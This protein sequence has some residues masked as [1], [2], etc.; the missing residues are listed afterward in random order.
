MPVIRFSCPTCSKVLK[1][2]DHGAGRKIA[3]PGCGQRLLI[4][5]PLRVENKTVLGELMPDSPASSIPS[6]PDPFHPMRFSSVDEPPPVRRAPPIPPAPE[7]PSV[8]Q[9]PPS[10]PF[11][12]NSPSDQ[13]QFD[14]PSRTH[15]EGLGTDRPRPPRGKFLDRQEEVTQSG[16]HQKHSGL[17]I[18][19]FLIA[20]LVVG[21]DILLA[22]VI[23][24]GIAKSGRGGYSPGYRED[25]RTNVMG[26][27]MALLC[28]NCMSVPLCLV[29]VGMAVAGLI[30]HRGYNHLLTWIGLVGNGTVILGVCGLYLL[31]ALMT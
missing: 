15:D 29:G 9:Q 12:F 24:V 26:G 10:D 20:L 17:G 2:P 6:A 31:G 25:L 7:P 27:G 3:C 21:L 18:A 23:A 1:A 22:V 5:P 8:P 13:D 11:D 30:A 14:Y 4:P 28:L 16:T 19:S